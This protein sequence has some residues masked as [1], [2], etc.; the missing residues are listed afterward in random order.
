MKPVAEMNTDND[1][2][3]KNFVKNFINRLLIIINKQTIPK[4]IYK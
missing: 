2:I 3:P 4:N 1:K